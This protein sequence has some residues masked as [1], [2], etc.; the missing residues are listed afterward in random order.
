M[1]CLLWL[2]NHFLLL[3]V[4]ALFNSLVCHSVGT[5]SRYA[6]GK[7][8]YAFEFAALYLIFVRGGLAYPSSFFVLLMHVTGIQNVGHMG[9]LQG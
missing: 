7:V 4:V 6:F 1:L 5:G 8:C 2:E 9:F 3:W